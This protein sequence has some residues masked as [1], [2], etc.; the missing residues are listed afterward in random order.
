MSL[1]SC[2]GSAMFGAPHVTPRTHQDR[3][4]LNIRGT[5][6]DKISR[7]GPRWGP[8]GESYLRVELVTRASGS[9]AVAYYLTD[10]FNNLTDRAMEQRGGRYPNGDSISTATWQTLVCGMMHGENKAVRRYKVHYNAF[11][12]CH[13]DAKRPNLPVMSRDEVE[14]DDGK[15]NSTMERRSLD[16]NLG[17]QDRETRRGA[18]AG[19]GGPSEATTGDKATKK[20]SELEEEAMPFI[21]ALIRGQ[22]GRCPRRGPRGRRDRHIL[23]ASA[24][25]HCAPR[26]RSRLRWDGAVPACRP[27]LCARH[28]G[29]G[30]V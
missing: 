25:L 8:D 13:K 3:A 18:G 9:L 1:F 29:R 30:D 23:R 17:S 10:A 22:T 11:L 19:I 21:R 7:A 12:E 26:G 16:F 2:S 24:T 5:M 6:I 4:K 28:H 27:L 15:V 20:K 14:D